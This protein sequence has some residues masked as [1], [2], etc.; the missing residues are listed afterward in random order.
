MIVV[1]FVQRG[2]AVELEEPPIGRGGQAFIYRPASGERLA[3][4]LMLPQY[5]TQ[6]FRDRVEALLRW[7]HRDPRIAFPIDLVRDGPH[8]EV[9]GYAMPLVSGVTIL[10]V[11]NPVAGRRHGLRPS[12]AR[13]LGVARELADLLAF[14][15]RAHLL[16]GDL[17]ESNALVTLGLFGQVLALH[18]VDVDSYEFESRDSQGVLHRFRSGVGKEPFLAPELQGRDLRTTDRTTHTDT[19]ALAVLIWA[20]VKGGHPFSVRC[21]GAVQLPPLGEIIRSGL[22]PFRPRRPLPA[23]WQANDAGRPWAELPPEVRALFQRA[24]HDGHTNP[25]ARP[26]AEEW[27][28]ALADWEQG[29]RGLVSAALAFVGAMRCLLAARL[30]AHAQ[31]WLSSRWVSRLRSLCLPLQWPV[32]KRWAWAAAAALL[33]GFAVYGALGEGWRTG[34]RFPPGLGPGTGPAPTEGGSGHER[35][36]HAPRLWREVLDE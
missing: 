25:A 11:Y 9:V 34:W 27:R 10:C 13:R 21:A 1:F 3:V 7:P 2:K 35:W 23:G 16:V 6:E 8:G 22:W 12:F 36:R 5:Q 19:F 15:H 33:A 29:E 20:L 30:A 17:N 4:K 32:G 18:A 26:T 31:R 24:F 28:D 14:V